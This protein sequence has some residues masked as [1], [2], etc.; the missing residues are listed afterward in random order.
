M[1]A[2]ELQLDFDHGEPSAVSR[3]QRQLV[4]FE[5]K[6]DAIQDIAS[7][8]RRYR[9][10]SLTESV[11]QIFLPDRDNLRAFEFRQ[12][13]KFFFGQ[14]EDFEEALTAPDGS[15]VFP[16]NVYLN[17]TRRQ[18][19]DDVEETTGRQCG[20]SFFFHIRFA[21]A[22]HTNIE[23]G[24][25]KMNFVAVRLQKNIGKNGKSGAGAND[26]LDLLQAF[27]QFFFRDTKFHL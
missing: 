20:R 9:I 19:T 12:W 6:K 22:T 27:E 4:V 11:A 17:F 10:G 25:G 15:G 1:A 8:V 24:C 7:L 21:A 14:P 23:I 16:I 5:T 3:D 2:R 18:I 13:R 26:V